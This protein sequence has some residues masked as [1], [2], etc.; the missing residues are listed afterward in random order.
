MKK[1][2]IAILAILLTTLS[3]GGCVTTQSQ[4]AANAASTPSATT[5]NSMNDTNYQNMIEEET[6]RTQALQN[7]THPH[8]G[9]RR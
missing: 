1:P 7:D 8:V 9:G 2:K 5:T 6:A 4:A 3:L